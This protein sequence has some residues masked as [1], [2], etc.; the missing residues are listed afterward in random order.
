MPN[1]KLSA[2]LSVCAC[3][4]GIWSMSNGRDGH[5]FIGY[6]ISM[7]D[8]LCAYTCRDT[9][10]TSMLACSEH[11]DMGM[12]MSMDMGSDTSPDCYATDDSF[13]QTLAYCISTH[14]HDLPIWRLERYWAM[15]V[16]GT[17]PHQPMPK[18][19]YQQTL[20]NITTRPTITLLTGQDLDK[21]MIVASG[22]YEASYNAHGIFEKMERNH[23]TYGCVFV[24][25]MTDGVGL[26]TS[27]CPQYNIDC[28]WVCHTHP[29]F[30]LT[31]SSIANDCDH[32]VQCLVG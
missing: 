17:L 21:A 24:S 14:C 8:P 12:D 25:S 6:G 31:V 15:N 1:L 32:Q 22:D 28:Y 19:T 13:L 16:A 4:P 11:M 10:S 20:Q 26:M 2:L 18:A 9:L 30:T 29:L 23:E 5:G 27:H 7:Y 3:I